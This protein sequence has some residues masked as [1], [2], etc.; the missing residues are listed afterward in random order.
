LKNNSVF[1]EDEKSMYE[2]LLGHFD[3][4]FSNTYHTKQENEIGVLELAPEDPYV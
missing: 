3:E 4:V 2:L 1:N